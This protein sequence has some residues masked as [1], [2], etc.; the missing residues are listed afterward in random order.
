MTNDLLS[1]ILALLTSA[2]ARSSMYVHMG[3]EQGKGQPSTE[4][5]L[6]QK[7]KAFGWRSREKVIMH[8]RATIG[9]ELVYDAQERRTAEPEDTVSHEGNQ[10][11]RGVPVV[12]PYGSARDSHSSYHDPAEFHRRLERISA[13]IIESIS[14]P[15]ASKRR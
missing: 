3:Q 10:V 15:E 14:D 11:K 7:L 8:D 2:P 12:H 9:G 6:G 1:P 5:A 4:T 13:A